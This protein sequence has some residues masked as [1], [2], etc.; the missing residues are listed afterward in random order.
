[1]FNA[2]PLTVNSLNSTIGSNSSSPRPMGKWIIDTDCG[3]DDAECIMAALNHLDIIAFTCVCG[4]TPVEKSTV[5]VAKIL[6]L[7]NKEIDIYPG[8]RQPLI[9]K[10][11]T[12]VA[13]IHGKDGMGDSEI[14]Q[15]IKGFIQCIQEDEPAAVAITRLAREVKKKGEKVNLICIGPL[16]NLAV[17]FQ[18]DNDL[19]NK[20]DQLVIMGGTSTGLGNMTLSTEYNFYQDPE[21]AHIVVR[22]F[23]DIKLIPWETCLDAEPKTDEQLKRLYDETHDLGL[24]HK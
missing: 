18:L 21:A 11:L 3:I 15:T 22:N 13:N 8:C 19:P 23:L 9:E 4:N 16:T 5:N 24:L 1:M 2:S 10:V 14:A 7:C 20:I 12:E 17:A 6:Q